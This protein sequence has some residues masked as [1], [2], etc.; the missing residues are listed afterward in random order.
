VREVSVSQLRRL[1]GGELAERADQALDNADWGVAIYRGD[2]NGMKCVI[3]FGAQGAD[4]P[5]RFPPSHYGDLLL[6]AYVMPEPIKPTMRS[7]LMD[8]EQPPQI[9]VPRGRSETLR[10]EVTVTNRT[11]PEPRPQSD[12]SRYLIPGADREPVRK[13]DIK[14]W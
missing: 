14:W 5:T 11:S 6:D 12:P 10:P 3:S 4:I 13:T 7:P 1:A 8:W 9:S 2:L